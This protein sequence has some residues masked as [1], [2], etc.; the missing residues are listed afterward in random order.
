MLSVKQKIGPLDRRITFQQKVV[1]VNV[2]NEDEEAGW[3]NILTTPTVWA[4]KDES[5][6]NE[7]YASDKLTGFQGVMF[8]CRY[9]TDIDISMRIVCG[10]LAYNIQSLVE[11]GR[12]GFLQ[13]G[14]AL[15]YQYVGESVGEFSEDFSEDFNI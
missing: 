9:R 15:G 5:S 6:G 8:T 11:I 2:S 12:K 14:T 1:G 10:D 3:E 7:T 4:N 13:I